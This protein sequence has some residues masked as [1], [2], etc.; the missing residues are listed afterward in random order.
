MFRHTVPI[1]RVLGI[2]IDLDY[3]WFLIAALT[4]WVLAVSYYPAE[5]KRGTS[6]EYWLNGR[7][8]GSIVFW[9]HRCA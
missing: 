1:G 5:F 8:N 4:T 2:P 6:V 3:S 7:C 9:Q